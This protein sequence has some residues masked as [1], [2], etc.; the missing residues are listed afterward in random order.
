MLAATLLWPIAV[1]VSRLSLRGAS[2]A[3]AARSTRRVAGRLRRLAARLVPHDPRSHPTPTRP[4]ATG[5]APPGA[6]D[7]RRPSPPVESTP[8]TRATP[9]QAETVRALLE[10]KRAR[11]SDDEP[12]ADSAGG[13]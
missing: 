7:D 5:T 2:V 13:A 10:R 9:A 1:A 11:R 4:P 8:V 12:P 3:G 6:P